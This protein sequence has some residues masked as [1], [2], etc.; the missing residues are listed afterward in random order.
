ML[1][2][3]S[4]LGTVGAGEVE[5][6]VCAVGL[7]DI[8]GAVLEE[9]IEST[10]ECVA[11]AGAHIGLDH[12]KVQFLADFQNGHPRPLVIGSCPNECQCCHAAC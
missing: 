1:S 8:P 5:L 9:G 12:Y 6:D 4:H 10:M 2:L 3:L 11:P 7:Q